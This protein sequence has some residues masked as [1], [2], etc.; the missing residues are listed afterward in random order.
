MARILCVEDEPDIREEIVEELVACGHTVA[1][2]PNG[3]IGLQVAVDFKP[4]IILCDCLMPTMTGPAMIQALRE[5]YP[6]F[7][8]TPVVLLSAYS[9]Q[10]HLDEAQAAG[11]TAYLRKPMDFDELE[12]VL[13]SLLG[14]GEATA[15]DDRDCHAVP[16]APG[17]KT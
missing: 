4:D 12:F 5:R 14:E 8:S 17:I 1:E 2:A 6:A 16:I 13:R 3:L 7:A 10:S 15:G 11:A 9:D